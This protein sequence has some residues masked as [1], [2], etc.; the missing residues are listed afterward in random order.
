MTIQVGDKVPAVNLRVLT[1]E[2]PK[3]ITPDEL[4]KGKKVAFFAVPGAFTPTCSQRHLPGY[5]DKA[6]VAGIWSYRWEQIESLGVP[7][8]T[9]VN[10]TAQSIR[11]FRPDLVVVATGAKGGAPDRIERQSD[12]IARAGA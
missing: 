5:V 12:S 2:G 10:A 9:G 6:D 4:F 11:E 7:V 3:E 1:S 8:K